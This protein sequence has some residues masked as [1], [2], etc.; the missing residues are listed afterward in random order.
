LAGTNCALGACTGAWT[1]EFTFNNGLPIAARTFYPTTAD[2][3]ADTNGTTNADFTS[4]QLGSQML[5]VWSTEQESEVKEA[6]LDG[7]LEFD[8]GR[9]QF[10]IDTRTTEMNRKNGYGEAVLGNWSASDAGGIPGM[11][12]LVQ[13]FSMTGL[14]NDFGTGGAAPG[15]WRGDAAALAQW[16]LGA[17]N[18]VDGRVYRWNTDNT[19]TANDCLCADPALDWSVFAT[20]KRRWPRRRTFWFPTRRAEWSGRR[21]MTSPLRVP[22][23]SNPLPKRRTTT[24][25]CPASTST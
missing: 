16:G 1:Q 4:S 3:V 25:S 19:T 21:T 22:R 12:S 14:F 18:P 2:A 9:F 10:G 23:R 8:N 20:R 13:Q 7:A 11:V 15:A 24:T 6:R 17:T 5:R